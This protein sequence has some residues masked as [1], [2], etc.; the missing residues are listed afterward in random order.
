MY[1]KLTL[2]IIILFGEVCS[3]LCHTIGVKVD[4]RICDLRMRIRMSLD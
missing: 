4:L 2:T 3:D 1:N